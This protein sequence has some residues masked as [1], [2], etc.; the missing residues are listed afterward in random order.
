MNKFFGILLY[1]IGA[2]FVLAFVGQ[3]TTFLGSILA[4]TKIFSSEINSSQVGYIIGGLVYWILHF[5]VIYFAFK[6]GTK[7]FKKKQ[8]QS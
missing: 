3:L 1:I 2:L 5:A 4:L 7:L 8:K 6:Y